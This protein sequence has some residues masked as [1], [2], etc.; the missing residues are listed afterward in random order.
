MEEFSYESCWLPWMWDRRLL[1][2]STFAFSHAQK[3]L[4]SI[5]PCRFLIRLYIAIAWTCRFEELVLTYH[6]VFAKN[7]HWLNYY[8][9]WTLR[10]LWSPRNGIVV[11]WKWR[12]RSFRVHG[13]FRWG[14][15]KFGVMGLPYSSPRCGARRGE[16]K[17]RGRLISSNPYML[18]RLGTRWNNGR[19]N[20][21]RQ[22]CR[23]ENHYSDRSREQALGYSIARSI[24]IGW[25]I[26]TITSNLSF[27]N[28]LILAHSNRKVTM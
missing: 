20:S 14:L 24:R 26:L 23:E 5:T 9:L 8:S 11:P 1:I 7:N 21:T 28:I 16:N 4:K 27:Y 22:N 2:C 3:I 19:Q 10:S 6:E 13:I 15:S 18:H 17:V 12:C 25:A